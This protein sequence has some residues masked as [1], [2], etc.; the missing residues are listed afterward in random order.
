MKRK[1][2]V[3]Y[4]CSLMYMILLLLVIV[5]APA[6]ATGE[7]VANEGVDRSLRREPFK[8]LIGEVPSGQSKILIL[9]EPDKANPLAQFDVEQLQVTGIVIGELGDYAAVLAPDG[10]T[11]MI[12]VGTSVG[13]FE[14]K[15]LSIS[16]NIVRITEVKK[17]MVG[18]DIIVEENDVQLSLHPLE[19]PP[20]PL[21]R[22][23]VLGMQG[24]QASK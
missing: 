11:Y 18:E 4:V 22:F 24:K 7:T 19:T 15:V 21:N 6:P 9:P 5:T 8:P 14:G 17:F 12:T 10:R 16:E 1:N 13:K 2:I 3:P 23:V 20:Q